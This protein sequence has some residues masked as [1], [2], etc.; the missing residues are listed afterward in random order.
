MFAVYFQSGG[1]VMY[2]V[3][4]A[5]IV[6]LAGVLDRLVYLAG[7]A[8]RR[9]LLRV[10]ALLA[11]GDDAAV[12]AARTALAEERRRAGYGLNRIDGVSQMATSIGLFGTVIG[13]ARSFFARGSELGLAA[14][15]V[16]ASGLATALFTTIAGLV[17][18]LFGQA[19]LI[20]YCEWRDHDE[21]RWIERFGEK[22][23]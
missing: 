5:W 2:V 1:P 7:R 16:L 14:P 4:A 12:S 6:V 9:P 3:L 23:A 20:A 15:D 19:F 21:R 10:E 8:W 17:V 13:I 18:F 22:V 11:G